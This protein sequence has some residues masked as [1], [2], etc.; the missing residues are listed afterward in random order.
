MSVLIV[1]IYVYE[2]PRRQEKQSKKINCNRKGAEAQRDAKE[3]KNKTKSE[4]LKFFA[5]FLCAF[6]PLRL[7]LSPLAFPLCLCGESFSP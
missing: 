2:P 1:R 6:A 3:N 4:I 7:C 5:A